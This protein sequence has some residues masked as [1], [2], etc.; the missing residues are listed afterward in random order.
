MDWSDTDVD[1]LNLHFVEVTMIHAELQF[2]HVQEAGHC[3]LGALAWA[4]YARFSHDIIAAAEIV[5][6]IA[7]DWPYI[8]NN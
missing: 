2:K 3:H 7:M 4:K 6:G 8:D 1:H 5:S